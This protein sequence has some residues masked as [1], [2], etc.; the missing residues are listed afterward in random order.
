MNS[1]YKIIEEIGKGGGGVVYKAYHENLREYVVLKQIIAGSFAADDVRREVDLLKKLKHTYLPQVL[2]FLEYDGKQYTVMDY[3]DGSTLTE[4]SRKNKLKSSDIIK[5]TRQ[6]CE[7]VTYL[8]SQR[9]SV[10]HSDIKPDN[11]M[12]TLNGDICLIDFNISLRFDPATDAFI[13]T[14]GYA[15]PEQLGVPIGRSRIPSVDK[16]ISGNISV[17]AGDKTEY[18]PDDGKT[19]YVPDDG[20][21]E[22]VPD[23]GKT[24]YIPDNGKTEYVPDDGKTEY[25]PESKVPS[26]PVMRHTPIT[27]KCDIYSIGAVMYYMIAGERPDPDFFKIKPLRSFKSGVPE[28][29]IVIAEKAMSLDPS[30]RYASAEAMLKAVNNVMKLDAR[31]KRLKVLRI[32]VSAACFA[33]LAASAL[34]VKYGLDT[35]ASEREEKYMSYIDSAENSLSAYEPA[36]A[37]TMI[38]AAKEY[39]PDRAEA[40]YEEIHSDYIKGEYESCIS[41]YS[42]N[43]T[44]FDTREFSLKAQLFYT[45]GEA[46]F[47]LGCYRDSVLLFQRALSIDKG[48]ADCQMDL[49][50]SYARLGNLQEARSVIDDADTTGYSSC[51]K[52]IVRSE[53]EAAEGDA[54]SALSDLEKA[55]GTVDDEYLLYRVL[56]SY[57][58]ICMS[59]AS[60]ISDPHLRAANFLKKYENAAGVRYTDYIYDML[61]ANY[62]YAGKDHSDY[63]LYR[64]AAAYYE[65]LFD[66]IL[67]SETAYRNYCE[68]KIKISDYSDCKAALE[69][70]ETAYP[71]A[72][73]IYM[74]RARLYIEYQETLP[75]DRRTYTEMLNDYNKAVELYKQY[76]RNGATD[77]SMDILE[78]YMQKLRTGGWIK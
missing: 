20:K 22:Y 38:A 68:I 71:D 48:M 18:V 1:T 37:D 61:A 39:M 11:I 17:P 77:P 44:F 28:G 16:N 78:Q 10:I 51:R 21:T 52:L 8:H 46:Y 33:G 65:K 50:I 63:A 41:K 42:G 74:D 49:A 12:I 75:I 43:S 76:S 55:A 25:V 15:P 4:Y 72:Y 62:S 64:Q 3:I 6:L 69:K 19:E 60:V 36:S 26:K 47:E 5:F 70:A 45:V 30:A 35:I 56:A 23:N 34:T 31:Y 32:L 13:G 66:N 14:R 73:W 57:S 40:Y 58:N 9:P 67:F 53:I 2:D 27:E 29:L 7:A 59:N 24:E 54:E